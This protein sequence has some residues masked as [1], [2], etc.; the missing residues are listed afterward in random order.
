M[1]FD[2]GVG[3]RLRFLR[4]A[5][6]TNGKNSVSLGEVGFGNGPTRIH[7]ECNFAP[8]I[9]VHR[10]GLR[11]TAA[12][13]FARHRFFCGFLGVFGIGTLA[14]RGL[15]NQYRLAAFPKPL[16]CLLFFANIFDLVGVGQR[17]RRYR[18]ERKV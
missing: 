4:E 16:F 3:A 6:P 8:R 18:C 14:W 9:E 2:S 5:S 7:S 11:D 17:D 10:G 1:T 13:V 15:L 12:L